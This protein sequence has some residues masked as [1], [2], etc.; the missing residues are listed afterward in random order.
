MSVQRRW[1]KVVLKSVCVDCERDAATSIL[2]T[3]IPWFEVVLTITNNNVQTRTD[4]RTSLAVM[5]QPLDGLYIIKL[6]V[7]VF[8][9]CNANTYLFE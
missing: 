6:L 8:I 4:Q 2:N 7:N 3:V 5:S 1:F 9:S